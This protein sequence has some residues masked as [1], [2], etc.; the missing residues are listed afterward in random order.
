VGISNL[1]LC[2]ID[3]EGNYGEQT[4]QVLDF[5]GQRLLLRIGHIPCYAVAD[6]QK[7]R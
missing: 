1:A 4:P 5:Q 6:S 7:E 3:S 2:F